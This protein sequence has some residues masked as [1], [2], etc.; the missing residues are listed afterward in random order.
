MGLDKTS[1]RLGA[2]VAAGL[3]ASCTNSRFALEQT[4]CADFSFPVYFPSGSD[5]LT[6]PAAQAI[7]ESAVRAKGCPV[8]AIA[9]NGL[10]QDANGLAARRAA[11][12]A[13]ALV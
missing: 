6:T 7:G 3:V 4:A 2:L 10:G 1:W 13:R 11:T 12:V 8:A 5:Q 9:I